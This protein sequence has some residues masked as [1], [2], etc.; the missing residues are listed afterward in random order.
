MTTLGSKNVLALGSVIHIRKQDQATT[1]RPKIRTV[2]LR[3]ISQGT[4]KEQHVRRLLVTKELLNVAVTLA[5]NVAVARKRLNH[6]LTVM[7][8]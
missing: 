6:D 7:S 5:N 8:W 1:M 3:M 4:S 2:Q